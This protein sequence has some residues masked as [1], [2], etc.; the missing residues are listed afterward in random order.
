M[1]EPRSS[2]IYVA[3]LRPGEK[4]TILAHDAAF[5]ASG[6]WNGLLRAVEDVCVDRLI[7]ADGCL[8]LA[9][10][11][12]LQSGDEEALRAGIGRAYYSLHH[13]LRAMALW[14]NK[15]DPD[16]HEESIQ[17]FRLLLKDNSFRNR[18]G[19]APD[20]SERVAEARTNRHV[21][22]YS[23]YDVQR[24]PPETQWVGITGG[25]WATAAQ[26]NCDLASVIF[27]SAMKI[28]GS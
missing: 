11:L 13:S 16:G 22:D 9:R 17:Q 15:W 25:T 19:L 24:N 21:A 3:R 7:R 18:S 5:P 10:Q 23:P 14:Q 27:H 12:A 26:F 20:A 4:E 2:L 1:A 6:L 28:I 8:R